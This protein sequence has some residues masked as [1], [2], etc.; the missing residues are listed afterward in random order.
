MNKFLLNRIFFFF[1]CGCHWQY[2][3]LTN[4]TYSILLLLFCCW[5]FVF[6]LHYLWLCQC[7]YK[8]FSCHHSRIC[9]FSFPF[10]SPFR[11]FFFPKQYLFHILFFDFHHI[12]FMCYGVVVVVTLRPKILDRFWMFVDL[13]IW[14]VSSGIP[15]LISILLCN[16]SS[17]FFDCSLLYWQP[18]LR[19]IEKSKNHLKIKFF[20]FE[21]GVY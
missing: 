3:F 15:L 1:L 11:F 6:R 19:Y 20:R 2:V 5:A 21:S 16:F 7:T 13:F 12:N 14:L 4:N 17:A 9:F 18:L 8:P 10:L